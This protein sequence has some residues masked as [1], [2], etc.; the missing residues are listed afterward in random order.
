MTGSS[1]SQDPANGAR[2]P[3]APAPPGAK[4]GA[5]R[6]GAS[7]VLRLLSILVTTIALLLVL[8]LGGLW[9]WSGSDGSLA[10]ALR[11]AKRFVP[12]ETRGVT[13]AIRGGGKIEHLSYKQDGLDVEVKDAE[14]QWE[15]AALL[16]RTL[17]ID[18]LMAGSIRFEDKS[19]PKPKE[20]STGPPQSLKLPIKIEIDQ[21]A[22]DKFEWA[23]PPPVDVTHIAGN[24]AYDGS[25]H[26]LTVDSTEVMNGRYSAKASVTDSVPITLDA[27]VSGRLQADV[28]GGGAAGVGLFLGAG[29][30]GP[31]TDL[32]VAA[33]AE[34][35]VPTAEGSAPP[36]AQVSA[37]V[38]PWAA[39]PLPKADALFSNFDAGA[40]WSAA[41]HTELTG[42][43]HVTPAA[44][45]AGAKPGDP[46]GWHLKADIENTLAGPYD[47]KRLPVERIEAEGEWQN[48]TA[49]IQQ[50]EAKVGGGTLRAQGNWAGAPATPAA[51]NPATSPAPATP[52]TPAAD[53][54]WAL[55]ATLSNINPA[56][57][58]SQM[59]ALPI[60]GKATVSGQ[61]EAIDFDVNLRTSENGAAA[62]GSASAE[63][64][65]LTNDLK[66]LKLQGASAKGRWADGHLSL[67][68]LKV[69]TDDAELSGALDVR[70]AGPGG[71]GEVRFSAPGL[72]VKADGELRENSG[73]G[74][75]TIAATDVAKLLAWAKKLPGMPDSV[76]Q[77]SAS[78]QATL[79]ARWKGGW[80]DPSLD[81][82]L[83]APKL[84]YVPPPSADAAKTNEA[85]SAAGTARAAADSTIRL[86]D[87]NAS[88]VGKLSQADIKASGKAQIAERKL[89]LNLVASAGRVG[90]DKPLGESAWQ[91]KVKTLD[92]SVVDPAIGKGPWKLALKNDVP[93]K[94]SPTPGA[95]AFE[96]GAG[97]AVLS[98]PATKDSK[99]S[100]ATIDWE[101]VRWRD[102]DLSTKGK[103][104][105]LPLAWAE[106][107]SG[108]Q[109]AGGR[110]SGDMVFNGDWD[111]KLGNK[112]D[113]QANLYRA[114]GDLNIVTD[115]EAGVASTVP[116]GVK[117]ARVSIK[118]SGDDLNVAVNW[119]TDRAGKV[120]GGISTKL[121]KGP[122][123]GWTLAKDAP[124]KGDLNVQLPKIGVWSQLAPPGWRLE[125]A[126]DSDV[127][128][129]GTLSD[130]KLAG[131][132]KADDLALRSIV[133]GF[134]F[135][136]G[137]LRAKVDGQ[138]L[139]I[140]EF[141]LHGAGGKEK[142]GTITAKGT[143]ELAKDGK[144]QVRLDVHIDHLRPSI[145]TDADIALSGDLQS[146]LEG[147]LAS[148]TGELKVDRAR[149]EIPEDSAAPSLGDDVVV[150]R[151]GTTASGAEASGATAKPQA[152]RTAT[153][154]PPPA[155]Q[156]LQVKLDVKIGLGDDFR[157]SGFGLGARLAGQ[158]AIAGES[159]ADPRVNGEIRVEDG[160]FRAYGQR[161]DVDHGLIRFTGKPTNPSLDI[162][163]LRACE[164][165]DVKAGVEVTGTAL[166][167]QV[168]LYS[169]PDV[170]DNDKLS[171]LV[172][173]RASAADGGEAALL[174]TAAL[175]FVSG[176][177]SGG[178]IAG[179]VGLD[180]LSLGDAKGGG[181][182]G[183]AVTVGKRFSK[184]FYAAYERSLSGA[185]GTLFLFYD[186]SKRLTLRG[187]T[188]ERSALDLI[189]TLKYD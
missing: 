144:P 43:A 23:G 149:I 69:R 160:K 73:A 101:P 107:A 10:Q 82:K 30:N 25:K 145:R 146:R 72:D 86:R 34:A 148:V 176:K 78:G 94:W 182:S 133:D 153:A 2:P 3:A 104:S 163:A 89:D 50:L 178:G 6:K 117:D 122:D 32:A 8:A 87:L 66:S 15:P 56:A 106:L 123:G 140:D 110:V 27:Q 170:P 37:R 105:G 46:A 184:N 11:L 134:E 61:G 74:V 155:E 150:R 152:T 158:L 88:V 48:G 119:Q 108:G 137:K 120:K 31:L 167:P 171:W 51:G 164:R 5:G 173:G 96:A 172:L 141:S 36:R 154:A 111:V 75:A 187:Q 14:L 177:D 130:P 29:A 128:V 22:V 1:D 159:L 70:P 129:A 181:A 100:Q 79:T 174:Q 55:R 24:Y 103:L 179:K 20:P 59:A 18:R 9:I 58:D 116:A 85:N 92:A 151:A 65:Q 4:K 21:F 97:K 45:P 63:A 71:Q 118:S 188:G 185:V 91:G 109:L 138:K 60:D 115:P 189:Y 41:P 124:L 76:K 93:F 156:A 186:L 114:S 67:S 64:A 19:P 77:T 169:D 28:P 90:G 168:R 113:V 83:D 42:E 121:S 12:L 47:K 165:C 80:R 112:L 157:V 52:V 26:R 125:G 39:Q 98:S 102:G 40:L 127:R 53:A 99:S 139:V 16:D 7:L 95:G 183:T 143:A 142:G 161:L 68:T 33:N 54:G 81:V 38:T 84:D 13:G 49:L 44:V 162:L 35:A 132:I 147:Q 135:T 62:P 17:K 175:A 136:G 166:L 126:I 180:E 57:L 131:T